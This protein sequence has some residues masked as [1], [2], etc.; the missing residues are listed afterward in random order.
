MNELKFLTDM[1]V[2]FRNARDWERYHQPKE[3]AIS[4]AIEAAELMEKF[5]WAR[6]AQAEYIEAHKEEI[7]DELA[8][9]VIYLLLLAYSLDID[10]KS[11]VEEKLEK[12]RKKYP[13][14][15]AR[16]R[17]IKYTEL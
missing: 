2:A 4:V 10:V 16:G 8:D 13:V 3:L 11:A 12:M 1:I 17:D 14:E 6:K 9:V 5:Q 7:A 15:K